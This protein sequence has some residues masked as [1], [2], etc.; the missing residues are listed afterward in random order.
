MARVSSA[1]KPL[2]MPMPS[3]SLPDTEGALFHS[4]HLSGKHAL[5]I[6]MCNHCPFVIHLR[7][8]LALFSR[9]MMRVGL[10]MIAISSNDAEAYPQDGP[11]EMKREREHAGYPFPYLYDADQSVARAFGATCTPDFFLFGES[12]RL[13][14]RGQFDGSRPSNGVPVTGEDLRIAC[15]GLLSGRGVPPSL[16]QRPSVGCSIKWREQ[17]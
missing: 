17:T 1:M 2:G 4:D 3:F 8:G 6:F 16:K 15:E 12:G 10:S 7:E 9:E 5:V 14:Y 13:V 11:N